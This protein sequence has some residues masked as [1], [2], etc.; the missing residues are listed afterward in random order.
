MRN[1]QSVDK[2]GDTDL[3]WKALGDKTR[4]R[5]MDLLR[6]S[7][8][9]T[10]DL[11]D[12]FE[13]IGRCA[14]MKHLNILKD[15]G[16]IVPSRKGRFRWNH[17]NATPI[18]QVY[19][20]WVR[21]YESIWASNLLRLKE[22]SEYRSNTDA[23]TNKPVME[24]DTSTIRILL[25]IPIKA[26]IHQV[27]ECLTREAKIW[28]P[29]DFYTSAR[30]KNF[31][32]EP[33]V[34]GMMYEDYGNNEGL[35]WANVIIVDSPNVIE[36]KGHLSPQ[37]GGPAISFLRLSLREEKALTVLTLT[38]TVLGPISENTKK[39]LTSGWKL[40]YEDSFKKYVEE[41]HKQ[42]DNN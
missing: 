34:G 5:L 4:R 25:E 36:F 22:L 42:R 40:L 27:W 32:I 8:K 2:Q 23:K 21:K 16:L 12:E 14:V 7:P 41:K 6:E 17:I 37:F 18:Q 33:V 38:D 13:S 39:E 20:R 9:T 28:W 35:L 19:E 30:T 26:S 10:G 15:A 11:V 3:I 1:I 29:K 31:V 24:Q